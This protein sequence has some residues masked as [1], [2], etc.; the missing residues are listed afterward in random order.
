MKGPV[1]FR[2]WLQG[3]CPLESYMDPIAEAAIELEMPLIFHDGTPP[4]STPLQIGELARRF[5]ELTV[6]L[7][8]SGLRDLWLAAL[9]AA[10][11][12]PNILLCLCGPAPYGI[13]RIVSELPP[14]RI[15]FGS[16]AGF[17]A[18]PG[19]REYRIGQ[20]RRL[21][22]SDEAKAMILG[23]NAVRIFGL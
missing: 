12:Y 1:K 7:G 6:M 20:I 15:L 16:D 5:P 22:V 4:Y 13:E 2:P 10:H 8:H 3:F 21:P 18:S 11:R 9:A 23:D 17:M 19:M 14:E